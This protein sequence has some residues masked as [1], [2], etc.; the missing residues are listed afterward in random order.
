MT[1]IADFEQ[2]WRQRGQTEDCSYKITHET[3]ERSFLVRSPFLIPSH[4]NFINKINHTFGNCW[5]K[6]EMSLVSFLIT[7]TQLSKN[8]KT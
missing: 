3:T 4:M 2:R 6:L 5:K 8:R 1:A 7:I